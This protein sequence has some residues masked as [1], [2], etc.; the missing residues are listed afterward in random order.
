[1]TLYEMTVSAVATFDAAGALIDDSWLNTMRPII[2]KTSQRVPYGIEGVSDITLTSDMLTLHCVLDNAH[3]K[4]SIKI[5]ISIL[6]ASDPMREAS[7]YRIILEL[8]DAESSKRAAEEVV[9][10]YQRAINR[11]TKLLHNMPTEHA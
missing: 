6:R 11:I 10:Y 5:P 7:R 2:R 4:W 3:Q 1:M 9:E 8:E